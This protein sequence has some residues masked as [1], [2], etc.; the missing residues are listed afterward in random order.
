MIL[1]DKCLE[2]VLNSYIREHCDKQRK[3]AITGSA[4]FLIGSKIDEDFHVA[5]IAMCAHPD[6][7]RDESGDIHSKSV[8][9]DWIADTGSRV[10]R[11]LPGGTMIVGLLWL[12]DSKASLQSAQVRDILVRALSQIAIRHNALSSLSIKPIDNTLILI[13][14]ETPLGKPF[15]CIIDCSRRGAAGSQTK[16]SFSQ[17]E[18]VRLESSVAFRLSEPLTDGVWDFHKQFTSGI[19]EWAECLLKTNLALINGL[20]RPRDEFLRPR[21]RKNRGPTAFDI[22]MFLNAEGKHDFGNQKISSSCIIDLIVDTIAKAA[23]PSKATVGQA[24]DAVKEHLIRSLCSRAELHYESTDVIEDEPKDRLAVHQLPR[25]AYVCLP[26]QR[27]IVFTDYL[28]ESDTA[29]DAQQ[30]FAEF[31]SLKVSEDDID[32]SSERHLDGNDLLNMLSEDDRPSHVERSSSSA[33]SLNSVVLPPILKAGEMTSINYYFLI[34]ALVA[35]LSF[36][37]Y[38]MMKTISS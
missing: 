9:A 1:L 27:A 24:I 23:V 4:G 11:F 19:R 34:A 10:L 8:D 2:F 14:I 16:V 29:N 31:L 17:L 6:T 37:A 18:W 28:F 21:D 5:H 26:S 35:L 22:E 32:I 3:Y 20:S 38:F 33:S 15:G 12:A 13:G 7:I 36:V 25:A 30:S